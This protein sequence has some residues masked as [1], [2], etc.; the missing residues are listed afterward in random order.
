[1]AIQAAGL[2]RLFP[3]GKT[4]ASLKQVSW[5]GELSPHEYGRTYTLEL[6][7]KQNQPPRVWVRNVDLI[8][9]AGERKLPHVYDQ[10]AQELCLY[11]PG[12]GFWRADMSI[13]STIMLWAWLWLYNFELWLITNE[14]H[15]RG[16][17]PKPE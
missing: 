4:T 10:Q 11:L 7:Y 16:E 8:Q 9:L 6:I 17:H 3:L 2:R 15:A 14:W 12:R 13:A 1:M 5:L